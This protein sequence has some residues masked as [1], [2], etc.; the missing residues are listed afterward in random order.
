MMKTLAI[1]ILIL[2]ATISSSAQPQIQRASQI[3]F[4][5][6]IY[7]KIW[8][9]KNHKIV[10]K[11]EHTA[12][13]PA[14]SLVVTDSGAYSPFSA[15]FLRVQTPGGKDLVSAGV[16]AQGIFNIAGR[17]SRDST[18]VYH[19]IFSAA[20]D[21]II[22]SINGIEEVRID[23]QKINL[24]RDLILEYA[25]TDLAAP[26]IVF[27]ETYLG[28]RD[29]AIISMRLAPL[30]NSAIEFSRPIRFAN[31][32]SSDL[33]GQHQA[34]TMNLDTLTLKGEGNNLTRLNLFNAAPGQ[35]PVWDGVSWHPED[36]TGGVGGAGALGARWQALGNSFNHY[37]DTDIVFGLSMVGSVTGSR[38]I[39]MNLVQN[40]RTTDAPTFGNLQLGN[41]GI[42]TL[43]SSTGTSAF[44]DYPTGANSPFFHFPGL[45]GTFT[46]ATLDGNQTF[47]SATWQA[48]P[49]GLAYY[50]HMNHA[51]T[52]DTLNSNSATNT[53]TTPWSFTANVTGHDF[54]LQNISFAG[55]TTITQEANNRMTIT[56][57]GLI[58]FAT[59]NGIELYDGSGFAASLRMY[60]ST[61]S[62]R[63]LTIPNNSGTLCVGATGSLTLDPITGI[64]SITGGSAITSLGGLTAQT[65]TFSLAFTGSTPAI[66][67]AVNDH[68]FR[69]QDAGIGMAHGFITNL[70]QT[71]YGRKTMINPFTAQA[72]RIGLLK[73][74][75]TVVNVSQQAAYFVCDPSVNGNMVLALPNITSEPGA[76]YT[77]VR[78]TNGVG[79]N[80]VTLVPFGLEKIEGQTSI[81][82]L[83]DN[84][85]ITIFNDG[86]S[87]DGW[88]IQAGII[89]GMPYSPRG[90]VQT[91]K[92]YQRSST[93]STFVSIAGMTSSSVIVGAP[94]VDPRSAVT[95]AIPWKTIPTTGGFYIKQ[96]QTFPVDSVQ[97]H[98]SF[99]LI[100]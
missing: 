39:T 58:R 61:S 3:Q 41:N 77:F 56:N 8:F 46:L 74:S 82:L 68:Q 32:P 44:I 45:N 26:R 16:N 89:D 33:V 9:L 76:K 24:K 51:M 28:A 93:D 37:G 5:D 92:V 87:A 97:Y 53:M 50:V 30:G 2:S 81:V 59:A 13:N 73:T 36:Q 90:L 65:Q 85:K 31:T 14:F 72:E 20:N 19:G 78:W 98:V 21:S 83:R 34:I 52:R 6:N 88:T 79:S 38:Q 1:A 57:S 55:P 91:V 23:G 63:F 66:V 47:S 49:V 96:Y 29:S 54:T 25:S 95:P 80:V 4:D 84:D 86:T 60:S 99:K 70:T 7:E 71:I 17:R 27:T 40:I 43:K 10:A 11:V 18:Q 35:V 75:N 12:N 64:M 42:L 67:S 69:F 48:I 100:P 62:N 94:M 15:A 22:A